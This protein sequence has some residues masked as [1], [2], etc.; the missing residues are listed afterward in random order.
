MKNRCR[1]G[2]QRSNGMDADGTVLALELTDS[3]QQRTPPVFI[4]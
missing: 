1:H 3:K 2:E 4:N